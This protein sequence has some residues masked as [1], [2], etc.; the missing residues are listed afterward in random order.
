MHRHVVF[1][2]S[3]AD[4]RFTVIW[5]TNLYKNVF[6]FEFGKVYKTF[7]LDVKSQNLIMRLIDIRLLIKVPVG[8]YSD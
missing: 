6:F 1:L 8:V 4:G 5:F 2:N 7:K 3:Q